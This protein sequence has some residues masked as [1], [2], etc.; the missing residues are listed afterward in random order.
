LFT[1]P[2]ANAWAAEDFKIVKHSNGLR[3]YF[4]AVDDIHRGIDIVSWTGKPNPIGAQAPHGSSTTTA[5]NV[6]LFG[7][8]ALL[9]PLAAAVGRRRRQSRIRTEELE[10][11]PGWNPEGRVAR[12]PSLTGP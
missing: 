8:A 10:A 9:L 2:N 12:P 7:A 6:G 11:V 1:L 4:L 5:M 3:T